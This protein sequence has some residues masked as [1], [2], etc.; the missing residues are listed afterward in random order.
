MSITNPTVTST[1]NDGLNYNSFRGLDANGD[2]YA[3]MVWSDPYGIAGQS[4]RVYNE[5]GTVQKT[6]V[7][8]SG[9]NWDEYGNVVITSEHLYLVRTPTGGGTAVIDVY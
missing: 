8:P 9:F 7:P 5:S 1:S 4:V 6:L 2:N 3:V